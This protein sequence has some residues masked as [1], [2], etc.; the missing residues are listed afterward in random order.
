MQYI[1]FVCVCMVCSGI[2]VNSAKLSSALGG[3]KNWVTFSMFF[4]S[5]R[6]RNSYVVK[7]WIEVT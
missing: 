5:G 6:F 3:F 4:A 1:K 7:N 2:Q